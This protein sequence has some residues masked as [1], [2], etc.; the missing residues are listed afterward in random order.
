MIDYKKL[1]YTDISWGVTIVA[2]LACWAVLYWLI[3]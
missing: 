3:G 1:L 2:G